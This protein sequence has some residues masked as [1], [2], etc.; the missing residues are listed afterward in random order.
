MKFVS[1][2]S[3]PFLVLLSLGLLMAVI[4]YNPRPRTQATSTNYSSA[5]YALDPS[6]KPALVGASSHVFVGRV[7]Q[8][9][10]SK[11]SSSLSTIDFTVEVSEH[12]KGDLPQQVTVGQF[13]RRDG[14]ILGITEGEELL[15]VDQSYLFIASYSEEIDVYL[16][17][18]GGYGTILIN[19][20]SQK[21]KL[22]A[23]YT[24]AY[25]NELPF[26]PGNPEY[27]RLMV[28][29]ATGY[30]PPNLQAVQAPPY[31]DIT[32]VD[33]SD[34]GPTVT[35]IV[36]FPDFLTNLP[37]PAPYDPYPAAYP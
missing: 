8:E 18:S 30:P 12:I 14:F 13:A 2:K 5:S 9:Q 17:L 16:L 27:Y 36:P 35:P 4:F 32:P 29:S 21:A 33:G 20:D 23:E 1:I 28:E 34:A 24:E 26:D 6:S 19:D 22:I 7:I 3:I 31:T 10:P 37:T 15:N 25:Q 11:R